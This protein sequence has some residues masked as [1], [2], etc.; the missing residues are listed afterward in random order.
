MDGGNLVI[1]SDMLRPRIALY[2]VETETVALRVRKIDL[3]EEK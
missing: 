2:N 1:S 3:K